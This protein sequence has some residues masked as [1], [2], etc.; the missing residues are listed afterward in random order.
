MADNKTLCWI[1]V[2]IIIAV[3][4]WLIIQNPKHHD[5]FQ[6]TKVSTLYG[7]DPRN[8]ITAC[9]CNKGFSQYCKFNTILGQ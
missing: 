4:A 9:M 1:I 3:V 7:R 5:G 8:V 2:I 6:Q